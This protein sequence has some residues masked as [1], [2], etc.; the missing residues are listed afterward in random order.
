VEDRPEP[1][2]LLQLMVANAMLLS[3]LYALLGLV[4][5]LGRRFLPSRVMDH[6]SLVLDSLPARALELVGLM[7]P[8]RDALFDG[9]ISNFT[10]RLAFGAASFVVIF[11]LAL[12]VGAV[13]G[14]L[15][16]LHA[17]KV[18]RAGAGE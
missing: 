10:V 9:R 14:G 1:V 12:L 2:S 7:G 11:V 3:G 6:A 16:K 8:L 5:E 17:R 13:T 15:R 4:A 18:G